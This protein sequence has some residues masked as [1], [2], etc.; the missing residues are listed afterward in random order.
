MSCRA[1]TLWFLGLW[2]RVEQMFGASSL[3]LM[4]AMGASDS[5]IPGGT[6]LSWNVF[7]GWGRANQQL[8]S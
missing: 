5:W 1:F 4:R 6:Q 7:A 3:K 8:V 2:M